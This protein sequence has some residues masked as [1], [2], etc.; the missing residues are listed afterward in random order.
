MLYPKKFGTN[1]LFPQ[2]SDFRVVSKDQS[3]G[4]GVL[5]LRSF[6]A[7]ELVAVISGEIVPD[8][9]QH[10][11]QISANKHL[12]DLYFT[13]Y[14][15]HSCSPNISVDMQRMT[16]TAV[17]DIAANTFLYMDYAETEEVL[18]KQFPCSC[19]SENCGGWITGSL[20]VPAGSR[21]ESNPGSV[22]LA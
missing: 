19:G 12:L 2:A 17:K 1:P 7:G 6:S 5:A 8:I 16:V 4:D 9:R 13:G 11:L 20:E 18:Y 21:I 22:E 3:S 10:T 14:L 15:L